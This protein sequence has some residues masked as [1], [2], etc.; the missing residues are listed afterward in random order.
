MIFTE[1]HFEYAG[2]SSRDY[3]LIVANVNTSVMEQSAGDISSLYIFNKRNIK[4]Y[5]VGTNHYDSPLSFEIE[6][7]SE[8]GAPIPIDRKRKI[9]KWLFNKNYMASFY[10]DRDDDPKL[11]TVELIDDEIKRLYLKCRFIN[12]VKIEGNGGVVGWQVMMELDSLMWWQDSITKEFTFT[13]TSSNTVSQ[14]SLEIDT[15]LNDYTYP[16][17]SFTTGSTG[18]DVTFINQSDDSLRLTKFTGIPAGTLVTM[19]GDIN[20]ISGNYYN[21]FVNQNFFRLID[22]TNNISVIGDVASLSFE[23]TCRRMF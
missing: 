10:I 7:L 17:V 4:R 14:A 5:L 11:E 1:F 19:N 20:H 3:G 23:Y 6:I 8:C 13:G 18:G 12:P 2:K 22:G 9:E 21:K 15:D 16:K